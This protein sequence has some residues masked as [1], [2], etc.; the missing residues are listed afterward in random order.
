MNFM[1]FY[2]GLYFVKQKA[3]MLL[4]TVYKIISLL[5]Q[6]QQSQYILDSPCWNN[7]SNA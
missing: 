6:R 3:L 2:R 4:H 7:S 5:Q 1:Y